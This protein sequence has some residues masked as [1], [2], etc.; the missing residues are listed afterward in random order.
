MGYLLPTEYVQYGLTSETP[1]D[2]VAMASAMIDAHCRRP[3]LLETQYTERIRITSGSETVRLSYRPL[4]PSPLVE[5][6]T[7]Y[8]RP[9]RGENLDIFR[10]QVALAFS[11]PGSWSTLDPASIDVNLG[12][13]E[14]TF[15][16]NLLGLCYNEVEVTYTAGL[17]TIPPAVKIACALIV[18]NAQAT[19]AMNVKSSRVDTLQ[20]EYF[21][22]SLLDDQV[23]VLLRPYVAERL[24]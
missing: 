3:S 2:L 17:D 14:L 5:V 6:K 23:L 11:I 9:R 10:E 4:A 1:D 21:S 20:M 15:P 8:G 12:A 24:G 22:D 7:R 13:A 18:R 19:P 16:Q